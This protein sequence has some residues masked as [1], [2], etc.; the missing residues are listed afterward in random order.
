[1][2]QIHRS[3]DALHIL[4][5]RLPKEKFS[6]TIFEEKFP[7]G[8]VLK[9]S[10]C[11]RQLLVEV[12]RG[13]G[14]CDDQCIWGRVLYSA[15]VQARVRVSCSDEANMH[16]RDGSSH[17]SAPRLTYT[18]SCWGHWWPW[19]LSTDLQG[20]FFQKIIRLHSSSVRDPW[21]G[22]AFPWVYRVLLC[23]VKPTL[24]N[25]YCPGP[26]LAG[27]PRVNRPQTTWG[28]RILTLHLTYVAG[29]TSP[30]LLFFERVCCFVLLRLA[31]Y[32][33]FVTWRNAAARGS[34]FFAATQLAPRRQ[35]HQ[36][37][38]HVI[39]SNREARKRPARGHSCNG[40]WI[41]RHTHRHA[42][43]QNRNRTK[44][45]SSNTQHEWTTHTRNSNEFCIFILSYFFVFVL[46]CR[47]AA[48]PPITAGT[49][50]GVCCFVLSN[51]Y[52]GNRYGGVQ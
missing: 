14:K 41:W 27:F 44:H 35:L 21:A 7:S 34:F 39:C 36:E 1:M 2:T 16:H 10:Q 50:T 40:P 38:T 32:W 3:S 11:L 4:K 28:G 17:L 33:G 13:A 15:Y 31:R 47:H 9:F 6:R 37:R 52:W 42:D 20:R 25:R 30:L 22:E 18:S 45:T 43:R 49:H 46:L 48:S 12:R 29:Y 23:F 19:N 51:Q 26:R 8:S 24:G 5:E